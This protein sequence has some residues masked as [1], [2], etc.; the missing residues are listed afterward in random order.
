M[1]K[2]LLSVAAVLCLT[3]V[4]TGCEFTWEIGEP[5]E[6]PLHE[7]HFDFSGYDASEIE[8]MPALGRA[9]T[10]GSFTIVI[11]KSLGPVVR[12]VTNDHFVWLA[13]LSSWYEFPNPPGMENEDFDWENFDWDGWWGQF[14]EEDQIHRHWLWV[15]STR[16]RSNFVFRRLFAPSIVTIYTG[17]PVTE[18]DDWEGIWEVVYID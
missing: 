5:R 2:R 16:S 9:A 1:M 15:F 6:R 18:V 17:L 12:V 7:F 10:D 11:D 4:L 13:D 8:L 14:G 3:L